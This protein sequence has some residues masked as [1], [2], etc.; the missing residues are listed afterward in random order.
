MFR[1]SLKVRRNGFERYEGNPE[2]IAEN[3]IEDC[4]NK[5]KKYFQVSAGHFN[6][7]YSRDFGMCAD[8]LV[9]QGHRKQVIQTLDYALNH[10]RNHGRITTSIS[11]DGICFDFP[12]YGADSL[13]FIIKAIRVSG[14]DSIIRKYKDFLD[15]EIRYYYRTVFNKKTNLVRSDR[16][17]SSMK[18]Y[19]KRQSSCYSNCML[20]MLARDL[21][22]LRMKSPFDIERIRE[23]I[24]KKFWNGSYFYDDTSKSDVVTGDANTFPFWCG[25][26]DKKNYFILCISEL[27]RAGLTRPFPLKYTAK[28]KKIH[29]MHLAEFFSFGYERDSIWM[30]LGLCFIDV[31]KRFDP[32]RF[33]TYIHQYGSLI[34]KHRN[35]LEVYA[36]DGKP[37][38][39]PLYIADESM[40]WVSKYLHLKNS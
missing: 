20:F 28:K 4:W 2:K 36:K 3:I 24:I 13:P 16:H 15:K 40:L 30:H 31:V 10:F 5:D 29:S 25:V 22:Y 17:F 21:G 37:F 34:G 18:D 6:E 14:A 1:R 33:E 9:S 8:A 38:R 26:T 11:P 19:A 39:S 32:I 23:D 7:F 12:Y 35:F 27:E